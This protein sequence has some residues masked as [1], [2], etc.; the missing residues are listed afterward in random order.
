MKNL[1]FGAL[2]SPFAKLGNRL[3]SQSEMQGRKLE[4]EIKQPAFSH[5]YAKIS[6]S[7]RKFR[8]GVTVGLSERQISHTMQNFAHHNEI[9]L[10][11]DSV[12]FLSLDF[13]VNYYYLLVI[14]LDIFLYIFL[15]L[16]EREGEDRHRGNSLN[17][18]KFP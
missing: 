12:R 10:C 13:C 14:N 2:H 8:G 11:T 7:M 1:S 15:Y 18:C 6:H 4:E 16:G 17:T 5:G 3:P 9:F